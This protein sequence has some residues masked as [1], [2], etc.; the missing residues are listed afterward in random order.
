[1]D[2]QLDQKMPRL[3]VVFGNY[4]GPHRRRS[5]ARRWSSSA[6]APTWQGKIGDEPVAIE[7]LYKHRSTLDPY[8]AKGEDILV[9]S[10][11]PGRCCARARTRRYIRLKGCPVSVAEQLMVLVQLSAPRIRRAICRPSRAT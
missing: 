3:H 1:M 11:R 8:T 2:G 5:R 4:Q 6:T 10:T 7:S 9:K